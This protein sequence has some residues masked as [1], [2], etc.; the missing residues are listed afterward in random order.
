MT[1]CS[2]WHEPGWVQIDSSSGRA[3]Q[4]RPANELLSPDTYS[5][6][7]Q[8]LQDTQLEEAIGSGRKMAGRRNEHSL[9]LS[10]PVEDVV[11][12]AAAQVRNNSGDDQMGAFGL[13]SSICSDRGHACGRWMA[14]RFQGLLDCGVHGAGPLCGDGL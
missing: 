13:R 2:S 14:A 10:V 3:K 9:R 12:D 11:N 5:F 4:S 7:S 8:R 1:Q 6:R